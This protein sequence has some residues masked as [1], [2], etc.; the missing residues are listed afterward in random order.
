M[1]KAYGL[2]FFDRY[3]LRDPEYV[4][5]K[6]EGYFNA[7]HTKRP[8]VDF[9]GDVIMDENENPM[10]EDYFI[11][12]PTIAGYAL[13]LGVTKETLDNY[14]FYKGE[15]IP[16]RRT[17]IDQ[18]KEVLEAIKT[19]GDGLSFTNRKPTESYVEELEDAIKLREVIDIITWGYSIIEEYNSIRLYDKGHKGALVVLKNSF[20]Y[21]DKKE[22]EVTATKKLEDF[23]KE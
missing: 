18:K 15:N 5:E 7:I 6:T 17:L 3:K 10:L 1:I 2:N 9:F 19:K 14:R 4:K 20:G 16:D 22:V 21:T 13:Y 23:M 8:A 12:P 11:T